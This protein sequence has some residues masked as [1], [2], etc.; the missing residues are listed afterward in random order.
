MPLLFENKSDADIQ[1]MKDWA[2]VRQYVEKHF[3]KK[4]DIQ[5]CLF[6]IGCNE[7]GFLREFEKEE[8]Q[9]IMH[10][11]MC[12]LLLGEY[13]EYERT[14]E[15]GWPHFID[16]KPLDSMFIKTQEAFLKSKIVAYFK[17]KVYQ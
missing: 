1:L 10:I 4:P 2:E 8:K 9:D 17:E 6:L 16:L 3:E 13:Y 5:V 12:T 7:L 15:D 14:D 11:G